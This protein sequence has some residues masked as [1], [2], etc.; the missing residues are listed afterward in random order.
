MCNANFMRMPSHSKYNDFK[1]NRKH[2]AGQLAN[3]TIGQTLDVCHRPR[4]SAW[5][6]GVLAVPHSVE[7]L[8]QSVISVMLGYYNQSSQTDSQTESLPRRYLSIATASGIFGF[9]RSHMCPVFINVGRFADTTGRCNGF[10]PKL[11]LIACT[12]RVLQ[13]DC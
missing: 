6:A 13:R 10:W 11:Q 9:S 1:C 12:P 7:R 8:L 4:L 3:D 5:I 2:I